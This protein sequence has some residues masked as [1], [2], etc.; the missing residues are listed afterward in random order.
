MK[1][2]IDEIMSPELIAEALNHYEEM[3][4]VTD[5]LERLWEAEE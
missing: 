3:K 1:G 5:G 4:A 2:L